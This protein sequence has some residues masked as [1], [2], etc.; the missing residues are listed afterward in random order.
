M[1][2]PARSSDD[3]LLPITDADGFLER[4]AFAFRAPRAGTQSL[5]DEVRRAVSS[6]DADLP[7]YE[8]HTLDYYYIK[9]MARLRS[10]W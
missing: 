3:G 4:P 2:G 7:L 1:T 9:S 5:M 8:I 6:V 10:H